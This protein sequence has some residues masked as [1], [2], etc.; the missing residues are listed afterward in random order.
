M[1]NCS[2]IHYSKLSAVVKWARMKFSKT[3][4]I[5]SGKS[6]PPPSPNARELLFSVSKGGKACLSRNFKRTD[7]GLIA[8]K[9]PAQR[10][11]A[12]YK[13]YPPAG[14]PLPCQ[15]TP[16]PH[17]DATARFRP[18]G[19]GDPHSALP[20]TGSKRRFETILF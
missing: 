19:Q 13:P 2:C 4:K 16:F 17:L 11:N 7:K 14:A 6:G 12:A 1:N 5:K 15:R 3:G 20:L 18:V 8:S 10:R 9:Q